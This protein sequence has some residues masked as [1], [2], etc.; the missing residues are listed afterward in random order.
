VLHVFTD[1]SEYFQRAAPIAVTVACHCPPAL[2][3]TA[4]ALRGLAY[5]DT[6]YDPHSN[7]G[8]GCC[9]LLPPE[10]VRSLLGRRWQLLQRDHRRSSREPFA[11]WERR[12]GCH[13]IRSHRNAHLAQCIRRQQHLR[14]I[15][16]Q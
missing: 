3:L 13:C 14:F 6:P 16:N 5:N 1:S 9:R 10:S 7:N 2:R 11:A 4:P 12:E 8:D 15:R